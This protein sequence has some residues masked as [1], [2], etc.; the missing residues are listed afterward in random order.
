VPRT[1]RLMRERLT[2][3][4]RLLDALNRRFPPD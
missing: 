1:I 3:A 4:R 2:E